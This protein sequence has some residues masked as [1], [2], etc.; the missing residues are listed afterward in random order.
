MTGGAKCHVKKEF[1]GNETDTLATFIDFKFTYPQY[2]T[3]EVWGSQGMALTFVPFVYSTEENKIVRIF[4]PSKFDSEKNEDTTYSFKPDKDFISGSI[5]VKGEINPVN[6]KTHLM[7]TFDLFNSPGYYKGFYIISENGGDVNIW[8]ENLYSHFNNYGINGF[9]DGNDKSTM[10]EIGGTANRIISV[11]AYVT[12]DHRTQYGIYYPS[13]EKQDNI[14]SFSSFGPTADG[15]T[16]PEISAPGTYIISSISSLYSGTKY[17]YSTVTW[18]SKKYEYGFMQGTSMAS[19]FISGVMAAWLQAYP[20]M[21]PEDA[22]K[23]MS[24][25][26]RKDSFTGDL[27]TISNT[28]GYGKIDAYEGVKECIRYESGTNSIETDNSHTIIN[29][30]NEIR[31]L[32]GYD[33]SGIDISVFNLQGICINSTRIDNTD[34]GQEICIPTEKLE[35]NIYFVKISG[36]KTHSTVKKIIIK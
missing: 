29:T 27:T 14:A 34:A 23:I 36:N 10:G 1:N 12:R 22:K 6:Q 35:S 21:T 3:A 33:D 9:I 5:I 2:G 18:N 8:T 4:E 30:G 31:I 17:K 15:R 11:G 28:W 25:T 32:F 13:G 7:L 20:E 26:A 19:P 16:K 24:K